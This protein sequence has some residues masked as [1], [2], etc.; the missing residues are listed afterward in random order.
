ML[1]GRVGD[2]VGW[3]FLRVEIVLC[4]SNYLVFSSSNTEKCLLLENTPGETSL[5]AVLKYLTG[6]GVLACSA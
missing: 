4:L 6:Y 5:S 1:A 3:F 2:L